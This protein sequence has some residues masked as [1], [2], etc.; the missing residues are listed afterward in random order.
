MLLFL[1]Q[2]IHL[3]C[4]ESLVCIQIFSREY[5]RFQNLLKIYQCVYQQTNRAKSKENNAIKMCICKKMN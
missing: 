1:M 2:H 4:L 3:I 5:S